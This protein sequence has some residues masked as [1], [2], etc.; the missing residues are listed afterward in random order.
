MVEQIATARF[1]EPLGDSILPGASNGN[2]NRAHSKVLCGLHNVTLEGVLAI[3]YEKLRSGIVGEGLSKLLRYPGRS[4][5]QCNVPVKNTPPI[6]S[7]HEEAIQHAELERRHGE[8]IH[9][10]NGFA[11]V[12]QERR[13]TPGWLRV[14]WSLPHPSKHCPFRNIEAQ[15][16]EFAMDP[17]RAPSAILR[18]HAKDQLPQ[19]LARRF[20]SNNGMFARNPFPIQF[21]SGSMPADD[22]VWLDKYQC[23]SPSLPHPPHSDPKQSVGL[24]KPRLRMTSLQ[25]R[26]LLAQGE[27][28]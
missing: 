1:D 17:R 12:A 14:S 7:N 3:K 4:R 5:M 27:I 24:G 11:M 16:S 26:E 19:F 2:S 10:C 25:D 15:H 8:E 23:L 6:M 18:H 28:L 21:E 20:P 13:P 9:R 22:R